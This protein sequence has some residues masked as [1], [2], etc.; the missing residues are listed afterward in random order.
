MSRLTKLHNGCWGIDGKNQHMAYDKLAKYED[1]GEPHEL[2]LKTE[3]VSVDDR[4]PEIGQMVNIK[5]EEI[6]EAITKVYGGEWFNLTTNTITY[7]TPYIYRPDIM[8]S[9]PWQPYAG[10]SRAI[11]GGNIT[12][13]RPLQT[14]E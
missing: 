11:A 2:Q 7:H 14:T 12:H 6:R 10:S 3:W 1:I 13:W 8:K 4:L 5:L 9:H